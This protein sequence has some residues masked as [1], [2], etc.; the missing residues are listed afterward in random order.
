MLTRASLSLWSQQSGISMLEIPNTIQ[1]AMRMTKLLGERFLWVDSLCI[2]Q[3]DDSDRRAQIR[4][5]DSIYIGA[6]VT[7]I[8][9]CGDD[10][11]TGLPGVPPHRARHPR[12]VVL[13]I[14]RLRHASVHKDPFEE[15][16]SSRWNTR[17]WTLQEKLL[18]IR[19]LIF[20]EDMTVFWC[21]ETICQEDREANDHIANAAKHTSLTGNLANILDLK[22]ISS[23]DVDY[24]KLSFGGLEAITLDHTASFE[25]R[26]LGILQAYVCR[27][28]SNPEDILNAF[29]GVSEFLTPLLGVFHWGFPESLFHHAISWMGP[30]QLRR[31]KSFPSWSWAGWYHPMERNE[32]EHLE[33]HGSAFLNIYRYDGGNLKLVSCRDTETISENSQHAH[34]VACYSDIILNIHSLTIPS[35]S[36]RQTLVFTTS[37]ALLSIEELYNAPGE[38][39]VNFKIMD[40]ISGTILTNIHLHSSWLKRK[41]ELLEFVVTG[42]DPNKKFFWLMLIEWLDGMAYR[43]QVSKELRCQ[44]W[45][46]IQ[47]KQ[48]IIVLA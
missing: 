36:L 38:S 1:D 33:F 44:Q 47:P 28:L 5:M 31:R 7:L 3:D 48:K 39:W 46:S 26:F 17:G 32:W 24:L 19:A 9:A 2:I 21:G 12:Q 4:R 16:Y 15:L 25:S 35:A 43:V 18:S 41:G 11:N 23:D 14:G 20:T 22:A 6:F 40:S 29:S 27:E 8:A 34:F 13:E 37:S 42:H 10:C 30:P 45:W